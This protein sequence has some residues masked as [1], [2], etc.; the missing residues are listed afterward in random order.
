MTSYWYYAILLHPERGNERHDVCLNQT[1]EMTVRF[2]RLVGLAL[3]LMGLLLVCRGVYE[4]VGGRIY[5]EWRGRQL[6]R[7]LDTLPPASMRPTHR[8]SYAAGSAI[9]RLEIPR[10]ELSVVVLEGSD[11]GALRLGVGRLANS[12]LPGE[13]GNVVLAGHRDTF[14][15]SLRE[16]RTGDRISLRT[17]QGMF[18][19][20]VDWTQ[21]VNPTDIEVLQPTPAPALTLVTCYP[22]YYLG[23]APQRFI[24][25]AH[26]VEAA[27]AQPSPLPVVAVAPKTR[28][29]PKHHAATPPA[30]ETDAAVAVDDT[31]EVEP[32]PAPAP[33][34]GIRKLD[35]RPVFHRIGTLFSAR[36]D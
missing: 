36:H 12:S 29:R 31:P 35:P 9:G 33:K 28:A 30:A 21:V 20:T 22:F 32:E 5:Q 6:D 14:F 4:A 11:A 1:R 13:P 8:V 34:R 23:S 2:T 15:R 24:V 3:C 26:P 18:A 25:R 7:T 10:I 16:I 19:Y 27:T 17:P